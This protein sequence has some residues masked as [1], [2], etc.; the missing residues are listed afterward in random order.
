MA[1]YSFSFRCRKRYTCVGCGCVYRMRDERVIDEPARSED[2]ATKLATNQLTSELQAEPN[3]TACP[4]CGRFQ[5]DWVGLKNAKQH[6][7]IAIFGLIAVAIVAGIA[8]LSRMDGLVFGCLVGVVGLAVALAHSSISLMNPNRDLDA[9]RTASRSHEEDGDLDVVKEGDR[10]KQKRALS[11]ITRWHVI[12]HLCTFMAAIVLLAPA[13]AEIKTQQPTILEGYFND[14]VR[15]EFPDRFDAIGGYWTSKPPRVTFRNLGDT[16]RQPVVTSNVLSSMVVKHDPV[17]L[18]TTPAS[19]VTPAMEITF[20]N[21]GA[22][23]MLVEVHID[24]DVAFYRTDTKGVATERNQT[25]STNTFVQLD[26]GGS[27]FGYL[28]KTVRA[29]WVGVGFGTLMLACAGMLLRSLSLGHA[30]FANPMQVEIDEVAMTTSHR[31][32]RPTASSPRLKDDD[33][34][35]L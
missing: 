16:S 18:R 3:A 26:G 5:P 17:W 19:E 35:T 10:S 23:S 22:I 8:F 7:R 11:P 24:L 25:V 27:A 31:D 14:P 29:I 33:E 12:A 1:A 13:A 15:I 34:P 30:A 2:A 32:D 28:R 21:S 9:N 20:A 6:L 4:D